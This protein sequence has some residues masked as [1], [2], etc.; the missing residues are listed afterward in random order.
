MAA[1][2]NTKQ[3][4]IRSKAL[5]LIGALVV[6]ALGLSPSNAADL[7][8]W[9][10]GIVVPKGDAGFE[11]MAQA[12]NFYQRYGVSVEF[13]NFVGNIQ[14]NQALIA[15][16]IDSGESGADPAFAAVLKGIDVK[17]IGATIPGN[18]FAVYTRPEIT[19]FANSRARRSVARHPVHS[20][21]SSCA[22]W[23]WP[24]ASIR[25][26]SWWSAPAATRSGTRR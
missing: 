1:G 24:K 3:I 4:H 26:R 12:K 22:R 19:S 25:N 17:I 2:V 8:K 20:P 5:L 14:L 11:L 18:P 16:Q 13:V 23:S 10:H 7:P 21:I 6:A 15:R 9:K